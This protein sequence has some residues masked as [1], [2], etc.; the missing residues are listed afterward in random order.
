MSL[1][2][3]IVGLALSEANIAVAQSS[4]ACDTYPSGSVAPTGYGASWNTLTSGK[5]LLVY[6]D[7]QLPMTFTVGSGAQNQYIYK[8]R[9]YY[10]TSQSQWVVTP[11]SGDEVS[12][13]TDW[14][15][16]EGTVVGNQWPQNGLF[17]VGYVCQWT[18][19]QWKCGCRDNA[20]TTN[21]WQLQQSG[22][23]NGGTTG[24]GT[25]GG[26]TGGTTGSVIGGSGI[27]DSSLPENKPL[28][29]AAKTTTVSNASQLTSAINAAIGGEHIVLQNGSYGAYTIS[30][31]FSASAPV[32]IKAQNLLGAS[33]SSLFLQGDNVIVSGVAV[34]GSRQGTDNKNTSVDITGNNVRLTRCTIDADGAYHALNVIRG[35]GAII[36]HC[37]ISD[38]QNRGIYFN[39]PASGMILSKNH[40]HH[41]RASCGSECSAIA[42]GS[43]WPDRNYELN[44]MIR[45][46]YFDNFVKPDTTTVKY[47]HNKASKIT[48]AFNMFG[49]SPVTQAVDNRNGLGNSLI[50][51][52]SCSSF[53]IYDYDNLILGNKAPYIRISGGNSPYISRAPQQSPGSKTE[54]N[55]VTV[56][57]KKAGEEIS[58]FSS[59]KNSKLA[60][61]VTD[62]LVVGIWAYGAEQWCKSPFTPTPADGVEIYDNNIAPTMSNI[63]DGPLCTSGFVWYKNVTNKWQEQAPASWGAIPEPIN[64]TVNAVGPNAQ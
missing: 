5:E 32:V 27:N 10:S 6:S 52:N 50:G 51:N 16:G 8:L 40:I 54:M 33:F 61:N 41:N 35:T 63:L 62:E 13:S 31:D 23:E 12:G 55:C 43:N 34:K 44:A 29:S 60:G 39:Q 19:S 56:N 42:P 26:A 46:N 48:I 30:R 17:W 53:L 2:L 47:V 38:F 58:I 59:A 57:C 37:D 11:L 36:D 24:G 9:Y 20:C 49:C 1:V 25:T 18:G 45:Y 4:V 3:V 14:L 21:F 22:G 28:P 7:C 15:L 64:F